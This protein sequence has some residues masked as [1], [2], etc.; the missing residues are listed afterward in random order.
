MSL[1]PEVIDQV[2]TIGAEV[3]DVHAAA[4]DQAARFPVETLDALREAG[5]L[6]ALIPSGD[7]GLGHDL[8]T[9]AATVQ[10]LARHCA[11]SAMILAMH[12]IQVACLVRHGE[13]P[14]IQDFVRR[15]A[16]EQLLLA[17]STTELGIGGDTRR[18][19]CHVEADG[20]RFKLHKV[21]PVISYGEYADAVLVTAR[22]DVDAPPSDQ[23]LVVCPAA[24]VTLTPVSGWDTLGFRG[25]C[26]GGFELSATGPLALV[27]PE[28]YAA[29]SSHTMLPVAHLLWSSLWLGI[30]DE[31][32]SRARRFVRIAARRNPSVVPPG[33]QRL[34]ELAMIH[35]RLRASVRA[36]L[37][38]YVEAQ[39]DPAATADMDFVI[40]INTLKVSASELVVEVVNK[41]LLVT[42]IAGYRHDSEFSMGRLLRDAHGA[43][44]MVNNDRIL[45]N[46][47]QLLLAKRG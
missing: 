47:S 46:T 19:S 3:A 37:A 21:S 13:T 30:A 43:A 23:V 1:R 6:G 11:S 27:C 45:G 29:I 34:A 12:H 33:A 44:V 32:E 17:S 25:T 35:Q 42:G 24:D 2:H 18:S 9:V 38:R 7:G 4:V 26:S 14:E 10:E 16:A 40:D 39:D 31:A 28:P 41:A 5:L 8:E 22:R 15:V 20:E 36:T